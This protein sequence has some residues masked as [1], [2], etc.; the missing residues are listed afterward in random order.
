ME[1]S[2]LIG[3]YYVQAAHVWRAE[4]VRGAVL[5]RAAVAGEPA[6]ARGAGA[7]RSGGRLWRA[8]AVAGESARERAMAGEGSCK[9]RERFGGWPGSRGQSQKAK[10]RGAGAF[11][12]RP[13]AAG[14]LRDGTRRARDATTRGGRPRTWFPGV[15][16]LRFRLFYAFRGT[17]DLFSCRPLLFSTVSYWTPVVCTAHYCAAPVLAS[18]P[19]CYPPSED[20]VS[21]VRH[22]DCRVEAWALYLLFS[23]IK[24][25]KQTNIAN[26]MKTISFRF[27][28][29]SA[30]HFRYLH[31]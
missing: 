25:E 28:F 10:R 26:N 31:D 23:H 30:A 22:V 18:R 9:I 12:C 15:S 2:K 11:T 20:L 29:A 8:G 13:R 4:P 27:L 6:R 7:R 24:K 14:M 21:S 5:A 3:R 16:L 19:P 17:T 1:G